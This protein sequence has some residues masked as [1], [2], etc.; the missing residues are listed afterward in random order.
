[1]EPKF[2]ILN[3]CFKRIL[4]NSIEFAKELVEQDKKEEAL[5]ILDMLKDSAENML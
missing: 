5:R 4:D 2:E 1:M 3:E